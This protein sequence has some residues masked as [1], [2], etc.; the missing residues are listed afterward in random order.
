MNTT[1]ALVQAIAETT[2]ETGKYLTFTLAD[3]GYGIG[4]LKVKEIIGMIPITPV[5]KTPDYVKGVINLR[6]KVLPVVDLRLKFNM[7]EISYTERTCIIV[8]EIDTNDETVLVGIVV[9]AV[10]EVQGIAPDAIE[11]PPA[12]GT[13]MTTD[14]IL[15][16][17]KTDTGVKIIL[18]ID[19]VL[20]QED[21]SLM[22][23]QTQ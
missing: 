7:G 2:K 17:A 4:I 10:S 21:L 3:E 14:Y 1:H 23:S 18:N 12:F 22:K 5:P 6:G 11:E 19:R 16:M 13:R 9:D 15:G 8:V 20:N